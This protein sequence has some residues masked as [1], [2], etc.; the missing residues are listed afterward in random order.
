MLKHENRTGEDW[1][2]SICDNC[3]EYHEDHDGICWFPDDLSAK[4]SAM[5]YGWENLTDGTQY[6]EDCRI[7]E[8][9]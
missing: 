3:G 1:Y 2:M 7:D 8:E 5:E 9:E 4:N 6:C